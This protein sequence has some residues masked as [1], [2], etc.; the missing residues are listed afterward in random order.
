MTNPN[1]AHLTLVVDRSGSMESVREDA[2]GGINA[3]LTAQFALPRELTLTLVEFDDQ[4]DA[5]TRMATTAP[6]YQLIPRGST[7]LVDAVGMEIARTGQDLEALPEWARPDRVLFVVV[8]DGL[9]NASCEF[10]L[11]QVRADVE[12]QRNAYAWQFQF[13]GADEAA[14]QGAELGMASTRYAKSRKG[15]RA[16]YA[17]AS[18]AISDYLV[19]QAPS[20]ML[21]MAEAIDED[22]RPVSQR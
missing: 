5:V 3:L 11:A 18:R 4:I 12:R 6:A 9:E 16:A 21:V 1:A 13:I 8:T 10:T 17:A 22:G 20:P 7:R 19:S 14:W 15:T 2:Q